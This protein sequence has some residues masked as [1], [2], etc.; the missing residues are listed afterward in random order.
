MVPIEEIKVPEKEKNKD[1]LKTINR[2]LVVKLWKKKI[3]FEKE[4]SV[5]AL[6]KQKSPKRG[7]IYWVDYNYKTQRGREIK[8]TRPSLVIS[9]DIQNG[10]D[11]QIIVAPFTT[12]EIEAIRFFEVFVDKTQENG[13]EQASK[14][15]CNRLQTVDKAVRL[16]EFIRVV[17]Y[18][19]MKK[20]D[21]ALKIV[22]VL[23]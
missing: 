4:R 22:L 21:K 23:D 14:I 7:E 20:V 15:L 5:T 10:F 11:D 1:L 13:L 12:E 8:K 3:K 2:L 18:E 6:T 17:N 19:I 16:K 9:N